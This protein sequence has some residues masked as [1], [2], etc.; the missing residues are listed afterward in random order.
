MYEIRNFLFQKYHFSIEN[1]YIGINNN[2][3]V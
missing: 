3:I 2:I 1:M